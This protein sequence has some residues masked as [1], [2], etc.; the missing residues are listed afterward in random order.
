[1]ISRLRD[2]FKYN[3]WCYFCDRCQVLLM[4]TIIQGP[5][6]FLGTCFL[7]H[8]HFCYGF[9]NHARL[10]GTTQ[11]REPRAN[12]YRRRSSSDFLRIPALQ[13]QSRPPQSRPS[14]RRRGPPQKSQ[15]QAIERNKK[16]VSLGKQRRMD[17]LFELFE[18][19]KHLFSH[20]N[21][22]T[23]MIQL[24]RLGRFGI[25][26]DDPRLKDLMVTIGEQLNNP[27]TASKWDARAICTVVY[28]MSKITS[29]QSPEARNILDHVES[30]AV[31]KNIMQ[32]GN[33]QSVG[34]TLWAY[35]NQ[36]Y[37]SPVV[38][39]AAERN[40][41]RVFQDGSPQ[42][43]AN[44]LWA[45]AKQ[46]YES[47]GVFAAAETN[48]ERVFQDGGP[49]DMANILWAYAKQGH[50]SPVVFRAAEKH[51]D[52]VLKHGHSQGIANILWAYA[53]QG[54]GSPVVFGQ[55]ERHM[56]RVFESGTPQEISNV[57][58]AYATIG[59]QSS[60]IFATAER[61]ITKI[62][63]EGTS[64]TVSNSL[65]AFATQGYDSP[66]IFRAAEHHIDRVFEDGN[67]QAIANILLAY[68]KQGYDSPK[69]F[70]AAERHID[71]AF[72]NATSQ[73]IGSVLW[74]YAKQGYISPVV[75][76]NVERHVD[77]VFQ[78]ANPQD[79]AIVLWAYATQGFDSEGVFA[80]AECHIKRVFEDGNPQVF[81]NVLWAY[82]K[83]GYDSSVVFRAAERNFHCVLKDGTPQGVA[84]ILWAY[85][86]VGSIISDESYGVDNFLALW[87]QATSIPW[88]EFSDGEKRQLIGAFLLVSPQFSLDV[89]REWL[90]DA[91]RLGQDNYNSRLQGEVSSL[92]DQ[93][94][95]EHE[96][97]VDA[98]SNLIPGYLAIDIACAERK[99]A[100]EVDG[101]HHYLRKLKKEEGELSMEDGSTKAKR[102][103][104]TRL[105]W[106]V[107]NIP[108]FE[109]DRHG[110]E[111]EKK[112]YLSELLARNDVLGYRA[113]T[114]ND[115]QSNQATTRHAHG[116][117]L[118]G[119]PE[120]HVVRKMKTVNDEWTKATV[121]N[122]KAYLK[123]FKITGMSSVKK[124]Q[125]IE[126]IVDEMPPA[127]LTK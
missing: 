45:Y 117:D 39:A 126:F 99:V 66:E 123:H 119:D 108:F 77:R 14:N 28:A 106:R 62:L 15:S 30:K 13:L 19:E 94:G 52:R 58:W 25:R 5:L 96:L 98:V 38:F 33:S 40:I 22:A 102:R 37:D 125:L 4:K 122:M 49:Q 48:I 54:D 44:I 103:F 101:P 84:T 81:A 118:P 32:S 89:P 72:E 35:A 124:N 127:K 91:R 93:L 111:Q 57:L 46:E 41:E 20:V 50:Q 31:L 86:T 68:A 29:F 60:T 36:E 67:Q 64:Q 9:H 42:H 112:E 71:P 73:E 79:I 121:A 21:F 74:A 65:W 114:V 3:S 26:R 24:Q 90:K 97:E 104:L 34:L 2:K 63:L 23:L 116:L 7:S 75:F 70:K 12:L 100:I 83:Q 113:P 18:T 105:G 53:K 120:A 78:S 115:S 56:D 82:A 61:Y 85:A 10:W 16:L 87:V 6:L 17:D 43:M 109:W 8:F 47:P 51:I 11:L 95:F 76:G 110:S 27:T 55:A 59:F 92:L 88:I 80:A 107:I 69:V 1:M